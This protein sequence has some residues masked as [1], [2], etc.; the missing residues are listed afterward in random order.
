MFKKF[1]C[2]LFTVLAVL[3]ITNCNKGNKSNNHTRGLFAIPTAD[4]LDRY[5]CRPSD[6]YLDRI[7]QDRDYVQ[8]YPRINNSQTPYY[9]GH[10]EGYSQ[11]F[12]GCPAGFVPAYESGSLLCARISEVHESKKLVAWDV[13]YAKSD[14][15]L[16]V[17]D[18][19]VIKGNHG[20]IDARSTD[21]KK[22]E[23][24]EK[25]N[26]SFESQ[27]TEKIVSKKEL[28]TPSCSQQVVQTC[29]QVSPCGSGYSCQNYPQKSYGLCSS[30]AG[31]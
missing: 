4:C 18:K 13:Q 7:S 11:G 3:A 6:R 28:V 19:S 26:I 5:D 22:R 16:I 15:G 23:T 17:S 25:L 2:A 9:Q 29:D 27:A 12:C 10:D 21:I 8:E 24:K 20:I 1:S 30:G 14:K 31:Y